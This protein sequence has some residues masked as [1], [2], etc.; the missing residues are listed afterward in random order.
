[1]LLQ[2][3]C[4]FFFWARI[5]STNKIVAEKGCAGVCRHHLEGVGQFTG[6][7]L[8]YIHHFALSLDGLPAEGKTYRKII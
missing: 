8:E 6:Y 4:W 2:T 5:P 1:M 7:I 3:L